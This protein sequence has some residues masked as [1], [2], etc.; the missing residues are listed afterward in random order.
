MKPFL[1]LPFR[2]GTKFKI[3]E[4]WKYSVQEKRIHGFELH[5]GVDFAA[6]RGTP[7]LAPA[8]GFAFSSFSL[9]FAGVEKETFV[10]KSTEAKKYRGKFIGFG[11]GNFVQIFNP[12]E[13]IYLSFG[14]LE[15]VA[16]KIPFFEPQPKDDAF[17]PVVLFGNK[18]KKQGRFI[19]RGEVIG[20]MGDSGCSWGYLEK[21]GFRPDHR[22]FFSWDEV[23]THFEVFTRD[24]KGKKNLR[25][26]PFDI[27]GGFEKYKPMISGEDGLWVFNKSGKPMFAK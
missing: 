13:K 26:D 3:T 1:F 18:L 8:D 14:H 19:N 16:P 12:K 7:I 6:K 15:K 22:K 23:H 21:P 5:R 20:Y 4:G 27:Y 2:Q 9:A 17:D 10:T 24:K 25:L 11:L